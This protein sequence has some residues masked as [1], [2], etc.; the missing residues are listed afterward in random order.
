MRED[1]SYA[2][3]MYELWIPAAFV[4]AFTASASCFHLVFLSVHT[5][6]RI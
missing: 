3:N 5:F 4:F 6:T 2:V 1:Y